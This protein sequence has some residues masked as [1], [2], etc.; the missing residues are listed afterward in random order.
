MAE[1]VPIR[2]LNQHT[3]ALVSR[4]A[5]EGRELTITRAGTPVARLVP[6]SP[7]ET[8]LDRLVAAGKATAPVAP[9]LPEQGTRQPSPLN[10]AQ[11]L[12]DDRNDERW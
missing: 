3:S 7:A 1:R 12:A 2:E 8:L 6:I 11:A 4:V 5:D 9:R 10:V